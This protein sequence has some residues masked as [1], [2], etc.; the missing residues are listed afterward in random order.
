M[1][2]VNGIQSSK[3]VLVT[4]DLAVLFNGVMDQPIRENLHRPEAQAGLAC[5]ACHSI[6]R[7]DTM[8]NGVL[9]N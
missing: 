4:N 5:T 3:C 2:D 9:C 1:Q 8:G 6:E 7:A